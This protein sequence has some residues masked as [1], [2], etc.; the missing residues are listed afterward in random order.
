V[1]RRED[2]DRRIGE[3]ELEKFG[4]PSETDPVADRERKRLEDMAAEAAERAK[5][6]GES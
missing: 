5:K 1:T 4:D 6:A 2:P 3:K